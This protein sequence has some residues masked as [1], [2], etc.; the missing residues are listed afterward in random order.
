LPVKRQVNEARQGAGTTGPRHPDLGIISHLRQLELD[1]TSGADEESGDDE[2]KADRP[3]DEEVRWSRTLPPPRLR[4]RS[5][6]P[7]EQLVRDAIESAIC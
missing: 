3:T 1:V 4:R 5:T 7:V 6:A 2:K